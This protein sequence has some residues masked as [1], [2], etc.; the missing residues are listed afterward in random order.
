MNHSLDHNLEPPSGQPSS[1][2]SMGPNIANDSD[3]SR[4]L[5]RLRVVKAQVEL[6]EASVKVQI[7]KEHLEESKHNRLSAQ[8]LNLPHRTLPLKIYNDGLTWI[9][10]YEC[11]EGEPLVGRGDSPQLALCDF[12]QHWLGL[13]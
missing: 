2:L 8:M 1:Q 7:A 13:K 9:A 3:S 10:A 4:Q 5:H 12:D 6:T 11:P